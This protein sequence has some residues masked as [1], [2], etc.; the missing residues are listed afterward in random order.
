MQ[1]RVI[2]VFFFLIILARV[3]VV[4]ASERPG[5]SPYTSPYF[6]EN[7]DKIIEQLIKDLQVKVLPL[8]LCVAAI[9]SASKVQK[10]NPE[11]FANLWRITKS[12]I[13]FVQKKAEKLFCGGESLSWNVVVSWHNRVYKALLPL[14]KQAS[15][16]EL[17]KEK[18][19][20]AIDRQ[21]ADE[22]MVDATWQPLQQHLQEEFTFLKSRLGL[23]LRY[24]QDQ[25][26][27]REEVCTC[28]LCVVGGAVQTVGKSC[29]R[30]SIKRHEETAFYI[31]KIMTYSEEFVAY[32]GSNSH[33][34]SLDKELIK[35]Y[36]DDIC[37]ALE[38]VATLVDDT[39]AAAP[40]GASG[41]LTLIRAQG[42]GGSIGYN[43][44]YGAHGATSDY[45]SS[46]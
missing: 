27:Q 39:T 44:G 13:V 16:M 31:K 8:G 42:T 25:Q 3:P 32:I 45:G 35:R 24:Y 18:R 43:G 33:K 9:Y 28:S 29:V 11:F 4:G 6:T 46:Y 19:I 21:D 23:H 17:A 20:Q 41:Q 14:T 38:H 37:S 12:P 34:E 2:L 10:M 5:S 15:V 22:H 1:K 26:Q 30:L 40:H 36:M 7:G